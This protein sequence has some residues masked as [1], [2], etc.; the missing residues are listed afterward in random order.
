MRLGG[1]I[2]AWIFVSAAP[3]AQAEIKPYL[4]MRHGAALNYGERL[5]SMAMRFQVASPDWKVRHAKLG[6]ACF[7]MTR[8][9]DGGGFSG[10]NAAVRLA[11]LDVKCA[12][13]STEVTF[14][15]EYK[16]DQLAIYEFMPFAIPAAMFG[17]GSVRVEMPPRIAGG[18]T[19][20]LSDE[21]KFNPGEIVKA[22]FS[23]RGVGTLTVET[24]DGR[25]FRILDRR[26]WSAQHKQHAGFF[27]KSRSTSSSR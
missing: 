1:M 9:A 13:D 22:V 18:G 20:K 21:R 14:E 4:S 17:H 7:R 3:W 15:A 2:L 16:G 24:L 12:G 23:A 25:P 5:L 6:N 19:V 8:T 11:S 26:P 10:E 27:H